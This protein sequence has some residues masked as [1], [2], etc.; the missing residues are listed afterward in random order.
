MISRR[1]S[2]PPLSSPIKGE[3]KCGEDSEISGGYERGDDL[4]R[5]K[6]MVAFDE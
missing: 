3:V 6:W 1:F 5:A 4:I 2:P